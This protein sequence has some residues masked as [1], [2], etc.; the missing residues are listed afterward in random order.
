MRKI[1]KTFPILV[2]G[3]AIMLSFQ[4]CGENL[5]LTALEAASIAPSATILATSPAMVENNSY[6]LDLQIINMENY[7]I[8][9]WKDGA[10]LTGFDGESL[11][12]EP[13]QLEDAGEYHAVIQLDANNQMLTDPVTL[14]VAADE[15]LVDYTL[16]RV[17]DANTSYYLS[18]S[19]AAVNASTADA[20]CKH[21]L[22]ANAISTSH[23]TNTQVETIN[24][25]ARAE[26]MAAC[27]NRPY[28][29]GMCLRFDPGEFEPEFRVF[30]GPFV[31]RFASVTCRPEAIVGL[32]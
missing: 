29:S 7:T 8:Q 26:D 4:N 9:W 6:K 32:E 15:T 24:N 25:T 5:D 11:I 16:P 14:T 31:R 27:V 10:E 13:A 30:I 22:G 21:E 23:V 1:L 12:F 17:I 2:A 3:A 20:Y 18:S 19:T 28:V